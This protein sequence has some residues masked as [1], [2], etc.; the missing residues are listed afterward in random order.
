[1]RRRPTTAATSTS[2]GSTPTRRPARGGPPIIV[3]GHTPAAYRRAVSRGHGWYGWARSPEQTEESMAGLAQAAGEVE[4]SADLGTLSITVTPNAPVDGVA[5]RPLRPT[6][7]GPPRHP[8][9]AVRRRGGLGA[10]RRRER[11]GSAARLIPR[12]GRQRIGVAWSCPVAVAQ[13]PLVELA[14]REPRQLVLEVDRARALEVGQV[15]PAEGD[16]LPLELGPGSTPGIGCTTALTASPR[17]SS[18]TPITAASITLG[19]VMRRF[20]VS[21]G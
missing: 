11:T 10:V 18:G 17:S 2:R 14:R 15:L 12:G 9:A 4:R 21:C 16:E 13:Q 3:G 5:G 6:G 1:M 19:W 20:S 7:S 8:S